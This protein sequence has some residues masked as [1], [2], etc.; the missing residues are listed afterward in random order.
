MRWAQDGLPSGPYSLKRVRHTHQLCLIDQVRVDLPDNV[1][2]GG[3]RGSALGGGR[4][5]GDKQGVH[6]CLGVM[7]A[8]ADQQVMDQ[9]S[10]GRD[11]VV[12]P[13]D[14]LGNDLEPRVDL[15]QAKA[16]LQRRLDLG[17][18]PIVEP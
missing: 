3:C 8:D 10:D 16:L 12:D 6:E 15:D 13:G 1:E 9:P 17:L 7:P 18:G 5:A 11:A 14:D 2:D 4:L